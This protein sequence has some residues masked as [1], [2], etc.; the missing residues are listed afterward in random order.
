[1][2]KGFLLLFVAG[3]VGACPLIQWA[4]TPQQ[5][6]SP[7]PSRAQSSFDLQAARKLLDQI[8]DGFQGRGRKKVLEAFDFGRMPQGQL[9]RQ[10]LVSL[11]SHADGVRIH[12]NVV[13]AGSE[14]GVGN[15]D[16]D[17]EMEVT[18][19]DNSLPVHK[20]DR[21]HFT[22]MQNSGTWKFT[23]VQPRSFFSLQP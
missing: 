8:N 13:S 21:L 5:G 4:Q 20:Q 11:A 23:D 12:F 2:M 10:Q 14:N 3:L 19:R 7:N 1:M 9:F 22:A 15:A 16:A 6:S 17:V 18:P